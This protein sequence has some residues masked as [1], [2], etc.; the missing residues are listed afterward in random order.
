MIGSIFLAQA[1][2]SISDLLA[3]SAAVA[4]GS[5]D[6]TENADGGFFE[7]AIIDWRVGQ[8]LSTLFAVRVE[9]RKVH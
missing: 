1:P 7:Q 3:F 2:A 6:A 5:S 4:T 9:T 8:N